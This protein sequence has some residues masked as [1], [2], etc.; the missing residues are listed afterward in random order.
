MVCMVNATDAVV[1]DESHVR[2]AKKSLPMIRN[3]G[4]RLKPA[5]G[6]KITPSTEIK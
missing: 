6:I 3:I 1:D 4:A 5:S 2:F